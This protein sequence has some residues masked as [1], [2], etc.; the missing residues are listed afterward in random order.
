MT[1][2]AVKQLSK[3]CKAHWP[4]L[5]SLV[6]KH[7]TIAA[8]AMAELVC[9]GGRGWFAIDISRVAV[10]APVLQL[11]IHAPHKSWLVHLTVNLED[12][13]VMKQLV[14]ISLTA[15]CCHTARTLQ[16]ADQL[17]HM[18]LQA[19]Q[20]VDLFLDVTLLSASELKCHIRKNSCKI[21]GC[22]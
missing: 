2:S 5:E 15:V 12:A 21:K 8:S 13:A 20:G 1:A 4:C 14:A 6:L 10:A 3:L 11:L 9:R 22:H 16:W 17:G 18:R 19:D 7:A